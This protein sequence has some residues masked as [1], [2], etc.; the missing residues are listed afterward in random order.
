MSPFSTWSLKKWSHFYVFGSPVENCVLG[1]VYGTRAIAHEGNILVGHSIISHGLHYPKDLGATTS[2]SYI[3][4]L[5][6]G[7]CDKRLFLS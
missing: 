2:S 1:L 3:L 5:Y 7:L 6:G 4:G